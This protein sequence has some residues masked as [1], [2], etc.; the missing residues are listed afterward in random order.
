M[1]KRS[2]S[3]PGGNALLN[4]L[5]DEERAVVAPVLERVPLTFKLPVQEAERPLSHVMSPR[6]GVLSAV[7]KMQDGA[8]VELTTIGREGFAGIPLVL[9]SDRIAHD[10]FVQIPGEADRMTAAEARPYLCLT[11]Q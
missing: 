3:G 10:I 7:Y 11:K 5:S 4:A 8:I 9:A 6:S 2:G 1:T